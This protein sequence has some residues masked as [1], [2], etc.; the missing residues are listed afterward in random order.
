MVNKLLTLAEVASILGLQK[1]TLYQWRWRHKNMPFVKIGR[2]IRVR[3]KDL[4]A[5]IDRQTTQPTKESAE[6]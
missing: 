2:V 6:K 5:F 4:L 1:K 3:E